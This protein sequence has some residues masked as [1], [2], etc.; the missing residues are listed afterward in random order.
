MDQ[1]GVL[2]VPGDNL[3][4]HNT[5]DKQISIIAKDEKRAY[6]LVVASSCDGDI[7]PFQQVWSGATTR[8]CPSADAPGMKEALER[9]F[10]FTVADSPKRTSHFSTLKTMKEV[11]KFT[12]LIRVGPKADFAVLVDGTD[13]RAIRS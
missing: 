13:L 1:T 7:L 6:T 9:G 10:H 8:S 4:Y 11:G 12:Y 2:L 3:T 5:G